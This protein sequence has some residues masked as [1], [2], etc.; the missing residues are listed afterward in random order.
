[1]A[2]NPQPTGLPLF[3]QALEPLSSNVHGALRL[4]PLERAPHLAQTHAVPLTVEEFPVAGRFFPIVFSS[5]E[6]STPLALMGLNANVNTF[7]EDDGSIIGEW[8]VP[9]YVRRYPFILAK[10]RPEGD[11]LSLCFDPTSP[12]IG[13]FDEGD[14]LFDGAEPSAATK[15]VLG[16]CEQFEQ[17][18][19][20]TSLF[21]REL[22]DLGLLIEGELTVRPDDNSAPS[23]YRGFRMID[24]NKLRDLR[25]DQMRKLMQSGAMQLIIAHLLS[26]PI[27]REIFA[28][29]VAQGKMPASEPAPLPADAFSF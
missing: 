27:A 12:A 15:A 5:D 17:A 28:R 11:E 26:L 23:T 6:S 20:R 9:A 2:T 7:V 21:V 25:G 4:R 3:Y 8:Y 19:Q 22:N 24:E 18:V 14:A 13:V 29:Q 10:L 1:M 16:F